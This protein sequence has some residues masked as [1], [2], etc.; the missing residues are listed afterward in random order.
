M[1][2]ANFEKNLLW[3]LSQILMKDLREE[4]RKSI[5][6][7]QEGRIELQYY[8]KKRQKKVINRKKLLY[9]LTQS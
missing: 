1:I 7:L 3:I 2:L 5:S 4:M 6:K 8:R 9:L